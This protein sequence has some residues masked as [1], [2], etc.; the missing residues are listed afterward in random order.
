[1]NKAI[2]SYEVD[3]YSDAVMDNPLP[4]YRAIRDIGPVVW[5][6]ANNLF[7]MGRYADVKAGLRNAEV[8]SSGQGIAANDISNQ[9]IAGAFTLT[10]DAPLH[11]K[12]RKVLAAPLLRNAL[13]VHRERIEKAA[14]DLVADLLVRGRFD[15]VAD[16]AQVLPLSVVS[17]LV[18]LPEEGRQDMLKWATAGFNLSGPLN[19]RAAAAQPMMAAMQ[20]YFAENCIPAKLAP[21]GWAARLYKLVETGE[22][23][24][25]ECR[26]MLIDYSVPSLD[27]TI[28][29]TGELLLQLAKNPA[30]WEEIKADPSLISGA[31]DEAV[32]LGSPVFSFT[33]LTTQEHEIDGFVIPQGSRVAMIYA[34]A[35]RDEREWEAPDT[36]NPR[37]PKVS[38][39]LGFGSGPHMCAGR[40]LSRLEMEALLKAMVG[41]VNTIELLGET[42]R[43]RNNIIRA[44]ASLPVRFV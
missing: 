11:N 24:P 37:R 44:Y 14:E 25:E 8:F 2:P 10:T 21:D 20:Q 26:M 1:M 32:R 27:T 4:H 33:R 17:F 7:A 6:S 38:E 22:I 19:D 3:L 31:V 34:S 13:E 15:G 16:F 29:A 18:G 28:S 12:L 43:V 5:L 42:P 23:T 35:N 41:R 36:F 30:L 40:H 39:H 9:L